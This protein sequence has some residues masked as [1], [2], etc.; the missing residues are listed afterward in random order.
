MSGMKRLLVLLLTASLLASSLAQSNSPAGPK[1]LQAALKAEILTRLPNKLTTTTIPG[2]ELWWTS[3]NAPATGWTGVGGAVNGV[4]TNSWIFGVEGLQSL[5]VYRE[6]A[7]HVTGL[8]SLISPQHF[9]TMTHT[10]ANL[11]EKYVWNGTDGRRYAGYVMGWLITN[12]FQVVILSKP[13]PPAVPSLHV[14]HES[15]TNQLVD[16]PWIYAG[17]FADAGNFRFAIPIMNP[18]NWYPA[19]YLG[20][21][22]L[23]THVH[24]SYGAFYVSGTNDWLQDRFW[25]GSVYGQ[26]T[27]RN[28]R[29]FNLKQSAVSGDSGSP[30]W[31]LCENRLIWCGNVAL[32]ACDYRPPWWIKQAMDKLSDAHKQPRQTLK[33]FRWENGKAIW[34]E[35]GNE[36]L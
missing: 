5:A 18:T 3:A 23:L 22:Q 10:G 30:G 14:A 7:D 2:D 6:T 17:R 13:L 28:G 9:I 8:P 12:D 29:V 15:L 19:T 25:R 32:N 26:W 33:I 24:T 4:R 16:C 31:L 1:T 34:E 20:G 21:A 27:N 35:C 11:G 36:K